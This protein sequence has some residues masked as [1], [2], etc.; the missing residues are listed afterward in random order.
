[1]NKSNLDSEKKLLL[2]SDQ[3]DQTE[4][5]IWNGSICKFAGQEG[6]EQ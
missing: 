4:E 2:V 5:T 1:M 6:K 3:E